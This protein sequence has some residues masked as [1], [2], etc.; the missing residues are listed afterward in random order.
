MF[1]RQT[2]TVAE[3]WATQTAIRVQA[4]NGG[5]GQVVTFDKDTATVPSLTVT[6]VV[7]GGPTAT[8]PVDAVNQFGWI[9]FF[10]P[11]GSAVFMKAYK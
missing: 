8:G 6:K 1:L 2:E 9:K 7:Y 10:L 5:T 11:D 4:D 3:L